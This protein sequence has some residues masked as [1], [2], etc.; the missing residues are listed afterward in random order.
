M[1]LNWFLPID[2]TCWMCTEVV[3][4]SE[5]GRNGHALWK[6]SVVWLPVVSTA[7]DY[8][9]V[10]VPTMPINSVR[11]VTHT[12]YWQLSDCSREHPTHTKNFWA[13]PKWIRPVSNNV[14]IASGSC[15]FPPGCSWESL[16]VGGH[17][18]LLPNIK[19]IL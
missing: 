7:C 6:R 2:I 12:Y 19:Y 10:M 4:E 5:W 8:Y 14:T 1:V 3:L 17:L 9:M 15:C 16:L 11:S 18:H 13:G